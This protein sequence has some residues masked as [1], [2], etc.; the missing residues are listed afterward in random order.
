[1]L[2]KLI[3]Y[4]YR[5]SLIWNKHLKLS[6]QSRVNYQHFRFS[7]FEKSIKK[8]GITRFIIIFASNI[9]RNSKIQ[10]RVETKDK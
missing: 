10:K 3:Y 1:M 4:I 8:I 2:Q 9:W 5:I 7:L 6:E